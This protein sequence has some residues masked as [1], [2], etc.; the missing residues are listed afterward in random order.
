MEDEA[1]EGAGRREKVGWNRIKAA[2]RKK[3]TKQK[4][5]RK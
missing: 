4:K 2:D 5:T 1:T 3:K